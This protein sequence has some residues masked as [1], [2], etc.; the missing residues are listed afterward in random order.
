MMTNLLTGTVAFLM[1]DIEGS[2][3]DPRLGDLPSLLDDHLALLDQAISANGGTLV[4]TERALLFG[5]RGLPIGSARRSMR[6]GRAASVGRA[7]LAGRREASCIRIGVHVGEA[8][9]AA[10]HASMFST[11]H[12]AGTASALTRRATIWPGRHRPRPKVGFLDLGK[13]LSSRGPA[14]MTGIPLSRSSRRA[15]YPTSR[16]PEHRHRQRRHDCQR[17]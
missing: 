7:R 4:S 10:I 16:R 11:L 1:T 6:R 3:P 15:S 12:A 17:F 5:F 8:S 2:T 9:G 13:P 14:E